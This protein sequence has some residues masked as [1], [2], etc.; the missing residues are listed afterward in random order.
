[1]KKNGEINEGYW[2]KNNRN[3]K[4]RNIYSDGNQ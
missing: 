3:G 4:S 2:I 1:M